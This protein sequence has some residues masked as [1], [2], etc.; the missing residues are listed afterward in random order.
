ML[1]SKFAALKVCINLPKSSFH[2]ARSSPIA[3]QNKDATIHPATIVKKG[4]KD[5]NLTLY[6]IPM[7]KTA[8][9]VARALDNGM[10]KTVA[11]ST[12]KVEANNVTVAFVSASNRIPEKP[13]G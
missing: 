4:F 11:A 6:D 3:K 2:W 9:A 12:S 7:P 5:M 1:G 8:A 13:C 10:A